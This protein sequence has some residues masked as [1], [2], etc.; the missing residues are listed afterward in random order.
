MFGV[1]LLL[2]VSG[3]LL[4]CQ[5]VGLRSSSLAAGVGNTTAATNE[6]SQEHM[7]LAAKLNSEAK[8]RAVKDQKDEDVHTEQFD[9]NKMVRICDKLIGVFMVDKPTPTEWRRLLTFSKEWDN[10]RPHFYTRC[11]D[12]ADRESD[13]GM[14]HKLL[15]LARKLKEVLPFS[16]H[17][18]MS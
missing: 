16:V 15:R 5:N 10:I 8:D 7:P 13:P 17:R 6:S 14:K 11:Q 18:E 2:F 1:K 9:D 12:Q 3:F 4:P